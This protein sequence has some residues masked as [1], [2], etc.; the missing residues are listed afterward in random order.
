MTVRYVIVGCGRMGA[1]LA[2]ELEGGGHAVTVVDRQPEAFHNLPSGFR[3]RTLSGF[4][5]DR[6]V[7]REAGIERAD[8]LAAVTNSDDA[9]AI[10]ARVAREFFRVP[11]VVA[12][13]YDPRKADI[14]HRLGLRTISTTAWGIGRIADLLRFGELDITVSLGDQ[15]ELVA[16]EVSSRLAG[17]PVSE[18]SLPGEVRVV[19]MERDGSSFLPSAGTLLFAGDRLHLAVLAAAMGKL[20][21]LAGLKE[22]GQ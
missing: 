2:G 3:G 15:V 11:H 16:L 7:L 10:T 13:L 18:L 12:R 20:E 1:G 9:N 21:R 22:V 17:H 4:A 6:E 19:A 5:F 8:G 14:Y